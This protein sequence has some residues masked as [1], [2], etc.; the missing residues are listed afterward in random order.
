M[1]TIKDVAQRAHVAPSTISK[2]INGGNVRPE[3]SK[4]IQEAISELGYRV[5]PYARSLK[6]QPPR[7]VGILMPD[8]TAP[9]FS[10]VL[11]SF[12]KA[13]RKNGYRSLT[14]CYGENHGLERDN[15]RFLL[16]AG[17][18]GL[19][20]IPEDLSADEFHELTNKCGVPVVQVDRMIQGVNTD[21]VLV[22]NTGAAY[23]AVCRLIK[24]G[25]ERI[26]I[27]TGPKSVFTAR[28][29][30]VGYLRA[31]SDNDI[32]YDDSL[33]MSGPNTFATGYISLAQLMGQQTPPTAIFATNYY[34]TVGLVTAVNER[35][36][37]IPEDITVFGFDCVDICAILNPPIS[38]V[39]Q[40]EQQLGAL[41][42]GYLLERLAGSTKEPR[43][44][45]LPCK[46]HEKPVR[47][48]GSALSNEYG[49][50]Y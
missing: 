48:K 21:A 22:D 36:Y 29:R 45:R 11:L 9:F 17:I 23:D 24:Q 35:G 34:I 15:L 7:S 12:D 27:V 31:L 33:V 30:L 6:T 13:M 4:A 43:V 49:L 1:A 8:M 32:L 20:Y 42:A 37:K 19:L 41:A 25:H 14:S 46:I 2:Y 47:T 39:E 50:L 26:A 3:V 28:E 18:D 16:N 5:N 10:S 40:P 44:S 38:V